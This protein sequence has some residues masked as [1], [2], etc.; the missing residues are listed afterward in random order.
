[1]N[2]LESEKPMVSQQQF[3]AKERMFESLQTFQNGLYLRV[4]LMQTD[5]NRMSPERSSRVH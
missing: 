5:S 2:K 4:I 3:Q 1:M